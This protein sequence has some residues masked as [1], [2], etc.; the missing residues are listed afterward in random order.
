[1]MK[2]LLSFCTL[3]SQFIVGNVRFGLTIFAFVVLVNFDTGSGRL[4]FACGSEANDE[5]KRRCFSKYSADMSSFL[6]PYTFVL[7]TAGVLFV[8]WNLILVYSSKH[9]QK[10]RRKTDDIE[11]KQLCH[12]LWKKSLLHVCCEALVIILILIFFYCTQEISLPETYNCSVWN[13]SQEIIQT[14]EDVHHREKS[15][16]N[17]A[18]VFVMASLLVLCIVTIFDTMY[19]KECFIKDLLDL[20]TKDN[21]AGKKMLMLSH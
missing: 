11:R 6:H 7:M 14:C 1:M 20:N 3:E 13:A 19:N 17:C 21:E 8:L 2:Y 10:I 12:E 15:K 5:L 18:Y 9:L 16:L 4:A